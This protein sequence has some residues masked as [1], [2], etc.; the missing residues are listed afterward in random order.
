MVDDKL[1]LMV[2]NGEANKEYDVLKMGGNSY[3]MELDHLSI[4]RL[5]YFCN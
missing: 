3:G 1:L 4:C 2:G 5:W